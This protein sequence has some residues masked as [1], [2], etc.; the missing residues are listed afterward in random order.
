MQYKYAYHAG[1]HFRNFA[2][3]WKRQNLTRVLSGWQAFPNIIRQS[4]EGMEHFGYNN[5]YE[6]ISCTGN[7]F[8]NEDN[9]NTI[10]QLGTS[11]TTNQVFDML[12]TNMNDFIQANMKSH[13]D[14]AALY[15]KKLVTYESSPYPLVLYPF[16][17]TPPIYADTVYAT[18]NKKKLYDLYDRWIEILKADGVQTMMAF[19]LAD[20]NKSHYGAFGHLESVFAEKPYLPAYQVLI[21]NSCIQAVSKGKVEINNL[22]VFPQPSSG[23]FQITVQSKPSHIRVIDLMG[24]SLPANVTLNDTF[25]KI[26]ISD[27]LPG[28]YF[29]QIKENN[30]WKIIKLLLQK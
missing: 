19:V 17:G 28:I 2:E 18:Y 29:A 9:Y 7:L 3:Y 14:I 22:T 15:T 13:Q 4:T 8:L 6:A 24:K 16:M 30:T 5:D 20:D 21:D 10:E 25:I 27:Q 23:M 26:D 11:L 1:K 12:E